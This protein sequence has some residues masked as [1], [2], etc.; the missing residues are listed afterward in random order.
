[1]SN[2]TPV[3]DHR[4]E[5]VLAYM[6]AATIGISILAF[7]A[8]MIGTLAGVGAND[9]FSQGVWPVILVLPLIGLPLGFILLI[10][11]LILNGVR[12]ARESRRDSA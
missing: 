10:T 6:V 9:G 2:Q 4:A 7:L 12:R 3:T 8:V 1:M 11:L 5:R